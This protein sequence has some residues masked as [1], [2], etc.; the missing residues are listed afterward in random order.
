MLDNGKDNFTFCGIPDKDQGIEILSIKEA[1][2]LAMDPEMQKA[3]DLAENDMRQNFPEDWKG[4]PSSIKQ[5]VHTMCTHHR[6]QA[7]MEQQNRA[8]INAQLR[9]K[10]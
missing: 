8:I 10:K 2:E 4:K 7:L 1:V 6:E 5:A 3:L 9:N